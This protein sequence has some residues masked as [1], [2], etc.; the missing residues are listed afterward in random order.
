MEEEIEVKTEN[1]TYKAE[2]GSSVNIPKSGLIHM[3]K[4]KLI[5]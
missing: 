1:E 4:K 5:G 2:K 3:F